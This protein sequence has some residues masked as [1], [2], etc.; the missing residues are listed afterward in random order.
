MKTIFLNAKLKGRQI[1]LLSALVLV[2]AVGEMLLPS[3]LAQMINSGVT[4]SSENTIFILAAVMAGITALACIINFCPI[5][6]HPER[7]I[8]PAFLPNLLPDF[9]DRFL[10]RYRV[11][12]QR[13]L[14]DLVLPAW[15]REVHQILRMCRIFLPCFYELVFLHL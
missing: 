15:L 12:Q 4:A 1:L 14:T 2:S 9:A 6:I 10:K 7:N 8:H 11:F 13:N 3:L 5:I